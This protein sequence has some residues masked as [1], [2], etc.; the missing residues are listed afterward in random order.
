[1]VAFRSFAKAP[2]TSHKNISCR[3]RTLFFLEN[4]SAHNDALRIF[5]YEMHRGSARLYINECKS[6]LK[7]TVI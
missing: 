1:M 2:K 7:Y 3:L 5:I 6:W 4:V